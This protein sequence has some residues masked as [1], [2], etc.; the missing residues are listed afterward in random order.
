MKI[1]KSQLYLCISILFFISCRH[2]YEKEINDIETLF[3][4]VDTIHIKKVFSPTFMEV[5]KDFLVI[6]SYG[7]GEMI[8]VYK[9]PE[10][11]YLNSFGSKGQGPDE[12]QVF[13]MICYTSDPLFFYIWGYTDKS[14]YKCN[15]SYDNDKLNVHKKINLQKY[16]TFN[17]PYIFNDSLFIYSTVPSEYSIKKYNI[18]LNELSGI[19]KIK[20][21]SD[22]PFFDINYGL[23]AAN[24]KNILYAYNYKKEIDIYDMSSMQ[25]KNRLIGKY[26]KNA[27]ISY[28]DNENILQYINIVAKEHY[29]YTL[30][31][32]NYLNSNSNDCIIEKFNYD[33]KLINRY[34]FNICPQIFTID[35][36]NNMIYGYNNQYEDF[37][38]RAKL[39]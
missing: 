18:K 31:K 11:K 20:Q 39:E 26:A 5:K 12:I 28:D 21:E 36:E 24:N 29:F 3:I 7:S 34:K 1:I 35:E 38:I 17:Q 33:G 4:Q 37:I 10:L 23:M 27:D 22:Q 14:I 25:L 8:H 30:Y 2:S 32:G 13:P 16:E 15:Y 19:I 9:L 6:T